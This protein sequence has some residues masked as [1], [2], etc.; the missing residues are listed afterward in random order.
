METTERVIV[1]KH[2]EPSRRDLSRV[3]SE[4]GYDIIEVIDGREEQAEG[5][6]LK[7]LVR[8]TPL[9]EWLAELCRSYEALH[10]EALCSALLLIDCR[11][12]SGAGPSLPEAYNKAVD[13][14]TPGEAV[15]SCGTA[16]HR[17]EAVI[18]GDIANDPLWKDFSGLAKAHDL[19]ACWSIPIIG[20]AGEVLG[21]FAVYYRQPREPEANERNRLQ[22]WADLAALAIERER[23]DSA[24]NE[25]EERFRLLIENA[26]EALVLFDAE[27]TLIKFANSTAVALFKRPLAELRKLGPADLSPPDQPDG[28]SS[29]EKAAQ[30]ISETIAGGTPFFEWLHHD[31]EGREIPCEV[32]LLRLEIAGHVVV[33]GSVLDISERKRAEAAVRESEQRFRTVVDAVPD[34]IF[35]KDR[36]GRFVVCNHAMANAL[37]AESVEAIIGRTADDFHPADKAKRYAADDRAVIREGRLILNREEEHTQ[38]SGTSHLLLTNKIPLRD[39]DGEVVG[40][41]GVARDITQTRQLEEQLRQSQKMEAIGQLAGGVA[42]DFNNLL[43]ALIGQ[44]EICQLAEGLPADVIEGLREIRLSADRAADLTRQLL[45]FSRKQ[46][47]QKRALNLNE[48]VSRHSRLLQRIIG[49]DVHLELR[50]CSQRLLINADETMLNQVLLN[51][52]VNSRDAMPTGGQL[53]IKTDTIQLAEADTEIHPGTR[54]GNY[55]RLRVSDTGCGIEPADCARIFEP[56]FTTKDVGKGTGLGLATAFGIIQQHNGTIQV[57]SEI[58]RGTEFE[59]WLPIEETP[60]PAETK[61]TA[62]S[63][64]A[65][66]GTETIL[67]AEDD[68]HVRRMCRR[69]LNRGGYQVVPAVNGNE[70]CE[71]WNNCREEAALL[72]TDLVMP[73]GISGHQLAKQL[74]ADRPQLKV[75]YISGY[76]QDIA[77]HELELRPGENFLTKPFTPDELLRTIRH[78]LDE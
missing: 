22:N 72:L 42:H 5:Q 8:G 14:V 70:A 78:C 46:V 34:L 23:I 2:N 36:D 38:A 77:G 37:G 40:L 35:I 18:V 24:R 16:A 25:S 10:P 41:V 57:E 3:L 20:S 31:S 68:P 56:F 66:G 64:N 47:T 65:K 60:V 45:L 53:V 55:A 28:Q 44:A 27:T 7:S 62:P 6:L 71:L 58:G 69:I 15:G 73:G 13:G 26:P 49:E 76:S 75:I 12:R 33:R 30:L 63:P 52:G 19:A 61:D 74:R 50:L 11:L 51:L 32:R 17:A 43:T 59:I 21:T 9:R 4:A 54:P 48:I 39:N 1:A 67:L 29:S